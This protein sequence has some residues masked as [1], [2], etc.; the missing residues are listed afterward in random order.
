[1]FTILKVREVLPADGSDPAG[2][3]RRPERAPSLRRKKT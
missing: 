3:S 2:T 1:M